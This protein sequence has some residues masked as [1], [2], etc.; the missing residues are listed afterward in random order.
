MQK[1]KF[2]VKDF[3]G[4]CD[5][6]RSFIR[7]WW[8]LL[9]KSLK[10]SLC[11]LQCQRHSFKHLF[12]K[13]FKHSRK[14]CLRDFFQKKFCWPVT[15]VK[16]TSIGSILVIYEILQNTSARLILTESFRLNAIYTYTQNTFRLYTFGHTISA[17]TCYCFFENLLALETS[18]WNISHYYNPGFLIT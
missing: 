11:F 7:N 16:R 12:C 15:Q 6:I 13:F 18:L 9:K 4:K 3:F 1:M 17:C 8:H 2:S 10:E 14:I 5:Q